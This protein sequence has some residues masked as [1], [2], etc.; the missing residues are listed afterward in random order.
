ML[1]WIAMTVALAAAPQPGAGQASADSRAQAEQLAT[2]GSYGAALQRFQALAAANPDDIEARLWIARLHH[3]MGH[4][5]RAL[6]VY[7]SIIAT[8]PRHVDALVGAGDALVRLGRLKEA[9][10]VLSRAEAVAPDNVSVLAAQGRLHTAGGHTALALAYYKRAVT[11]DGADA[12]ARGEL[13]AVQ[14]DRAHRV[15]LGYFF[16][17]F[18]LEDTSNSQAGMATI[19]LRAAESFRVSGTVQH[20]RK[21][22]ESE[23]RGGA[24][25]EW[26]LTPAVQV[27]GGALFAGDS[28]VLPKSDAYGG[29]NYRRG[30][31]T[32]SF[33][34]RVAEFQQADA[35]IGGVGLRLSLPR[36]TNAWVKYY[37]FSTDYELA[38]SDIVHSWVL[39][40]SGRPNAE[41]VLGAEYTRGPDQLEMLTVDRLGAFE[42]NTY[43]AF[44]EFLLTPMLSLHARYDFQDRP[45]EVRVHRAVLR[46]VHRF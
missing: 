34:L 28:I 20:E 41:W 7:D 42:T 33:D 1:I 21:F 4:D 24:G 11:I 10:D 15:E 38:P 40:V 45:S 37:R 26:L 22:S 25:I 19:N 27:H 2:S 3:W 18:N 30:R 12:V 29:I 6:D 46:L 35:Q 13:E 17:H 14:R 16:E 32:W 8:N 39:G 43:S 9:G 44:T 23:T 31:A 36:N 5:S